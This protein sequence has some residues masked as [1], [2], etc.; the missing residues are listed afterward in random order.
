MSGTRDTGGSGRGRPTVLT[1]SQAA[2]VSPSTVSRALKGDTRISPATRR[3]IAALAAEVG[4][5]P[6]AVARTL[7]S[8][9]SG[10]IGLVL[11]EM[12]NP[13]YVELLEEAFAQAARRGVRLLLLHV[14]AGPVEER[15]AEALLQHRLDGALITSAELTSRAADIC[16]SS[17]VPVVMVNRVPRR[18]SSAVSCD[19]AE[20]GRQLAEFLLAAGHRRF[21]LVRGTHG[22][23]TSIDRETGFEAALREAGAEVALRLEGGSRYEGGFAA[24]RQLAALPAAQRPDAVFAINDVMAMGVLDALRQ[25]GLLAPRDISV[26]G[27]DNL[28]QAA[29]PAYDLTTVAQPLQAMVR[30]SLDLLL[31]R[32]GERGLP[33]E[34]ILL[35]GELVVRGSAREPRPALTAMAPGA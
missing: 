23:S 7:S 22:A 35:R 21:A 11:G 33:D 5:T 25:C 2:G 29:H 14:G 1:L 10:M 30:R 3:R 26:V 6:D 9:R 17:G 15:T 16:A 31:A 32:A 28:L 19:N 34:T 18:H 12:R 24:G 20:G 4:Y 27:F 8:G 13:F